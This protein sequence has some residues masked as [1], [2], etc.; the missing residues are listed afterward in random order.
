MEHCKVFLDKTYRDIYGEDEDETKISTP[1]RPYRDR[2]CRINDKSIFEQDT[3]FI[4][5]LS[6]WISA[7][8][9][10]RFEAENNT[11]VI[12]EDLPDKFLAGSYHE[13]RYI[14]INQSLCQDQVCS[15]SLG[16]KGFICL[17]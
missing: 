4:W 9:G 16:V 14:N 5:T 3:H 8:F 11:I 12:D 2:L 10:L 1:R 13:F 15:K 7:R 6:D 17:F